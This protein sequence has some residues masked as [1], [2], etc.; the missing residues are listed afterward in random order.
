MRPAIVS[1]DHLPTAFTAR[2]SRIDASKVLENTPRPPLNPTLSAVV[3]ARPG[4]TFG[5]DTHFRVGDANPG[6]F[7]PFVRGAGRDRECTRKQQAASEVGAVLGSGHRARA[8]VVVKGQKRIQRGG[9]DG[10][11]VAERHPGDQR[12]VTVEVVSQR[13]RDAGPMFRRRR[14]DGGKVA[15]SNPRTDEQ[16]HDRRESKH[17]AAGGMGARATSPPS[18]GR[19]ESRRQG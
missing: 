3:S 6:R 1:A 7:A 15:R 8:D 13:R 9:R 17:G 19:N 18:R 2:V 16:K 11:A 4:T 5:P 12:L 10:R 14:R